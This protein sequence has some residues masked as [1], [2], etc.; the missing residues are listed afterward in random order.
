MI[1]PLSISR[2]KSALFQA[3]G[4]AVA[5]GVLCPLPGKWQPEKCPPCHEV[6][7]VISFGLLAMLVSVS[8]GRG[9]TMCALVSH[10]L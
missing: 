10:D 6:P 1:G 4:I 9:D 2:G 7:S 8:Q 3:D 5:M